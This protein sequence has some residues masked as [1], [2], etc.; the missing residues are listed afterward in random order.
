[1][2]SPGCGVRDFPRKQA[3]TSVVSRDYQKT[4]RTHTHTKSNQWSKRKEI[5][6]G[7]RGKKKHDNILDVQTN[8]LL[9]VST[10]S[11]VEYPC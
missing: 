1:M 9:I 10:L 7:G 8:M 4:K 6:K 3:A 11:L 2:R 5:E